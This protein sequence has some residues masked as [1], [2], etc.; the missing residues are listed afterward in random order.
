M[1]EITTLTECRS[2]RKMAIKR[3]AII[4]ARDESL[5]AFIPA[6]QSIA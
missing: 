2:T 4:L 6:R 3:T 1:G 5:D